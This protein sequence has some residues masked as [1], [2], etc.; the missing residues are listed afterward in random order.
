MVVN[1]ITKIVVVVNVCVVA[2]VVVVDNIVVH[3]KKS[4]FPDMDV[5]I[6]L[7]GSS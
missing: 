4:C 6:G 7:K 5:V 1:D 3:R 2:D